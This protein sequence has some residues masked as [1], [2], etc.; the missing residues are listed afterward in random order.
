MSSSFADR[1]RRS[2]RL[3]SHSRGVPRHSH[4]EA[5]AVRAAHPA[6]GLTYNARRGRPVTPA[7]I[8]AALADFP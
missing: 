3:L 2:R 6:S 8:R 5:R 4:D 1:A 7:E